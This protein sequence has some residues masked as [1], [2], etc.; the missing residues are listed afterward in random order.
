VIFSAGA[1]W[2]DYLYIAGARQPLA[3]YRL[4]TSTAQFRL[5]TSTKVPSGGFGFPGSTP[6]VSAMGTANGVVW[7]LDNSQYCTFASPGCGPAVLHAYDATNVA[8]E[9]WNSS[10]ARADAA[11]NAVKFVVPTVANGK[12][13]VATRGNNTGGVH[14]STSVSGELDVYGLQPN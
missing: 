12:V 11:G 4:S 13:Y 10:M 3:A 7:I 5:V 6:S 14:G 8:T 9:L 1:F 2:N